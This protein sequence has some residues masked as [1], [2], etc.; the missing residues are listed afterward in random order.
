MLDTVT[1]RLRQ[2]KYKINDHSNFSPSTEGF[3]V[4]PYV[5]MGSR[6]YIDAYNNFKS[7]NSKYYP[8]LTARKRIV[9]GGFEIFLLIQLSVPKLLHNNNFDEIDNDDFEN[10]VFTLFQRLNE[11][12]VITNPKCIESA[13][14]IKV[15]FG[16]NIILS[17][18]ILVPIVLNELHKVDFSLIYDLQDKD[19]RNGGKMVRIH[20]KSFELAFYDKKKDMLKDKKEG[21]KGNNIQTSLFDVVAKNIQVLR[22]EARLNNK[23]KINRDLGDLIFKDLFIGSKS[24]NYLQKEWDKV[25]QGYKLLN[26]KI[27]DYESFYAKASLVKG[28]KITTIQSVYT[29]LEANRTM[30]VRNY[31]NLIETRYSKRTWYSQVKQAK[32]Y[33]NNVDVPDFITAIRNQLKEFE[34]VQYGDY[35]FLI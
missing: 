11:M 29:F 22:I 32:K 1:I 19:Y 27:P 28:S 23:Q 3:Y 2:K 34:K 8:Q 10:I 24:K 35:R 13:E 15:H 31:R 16:K 6:G 5:R 18:G 7:K 21:K 9:K 17:N 25:E 26:A 12:G 20:C 30:G 4:S 33:I 14:V